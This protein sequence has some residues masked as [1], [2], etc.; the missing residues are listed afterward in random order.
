[1]FPLIFILQG[2]RKS[3]VFLIFSYTALSYELRKKYITCYD[4]KIY[5]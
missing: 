5:N 2:A 4:N 3:S 1:M